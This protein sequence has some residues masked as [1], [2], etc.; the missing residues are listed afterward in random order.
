LAEV[1]WIKVPT[2]FFENEIIEEIRDLPDGD[3]TVLLYLELMFD[4]FRESRKGLFDIAN[5]V[6]TDEDISHC[7]RDRYHNIGE[8]LKTLEAF[9]L[10]ERKERS[11]QVFKFWQDNHDRNSDRY[12]TW[13]S[14]VFNRDSYQ[15][16]GCGTKKTIQAHHIKSWK[17]NK[18]LRYEVSNGITLC[19]K[20]HLKA[21]GG[22]WK[23]G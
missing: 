22:C 21:H 4:T 14:E 23:N 11:I 18:A 8:K 3:S 7:F 16:Q 10:I 20:C 13:R 1:K 17:S 6:L 19:R 15:C 5:I 9:G 12:K 2:N